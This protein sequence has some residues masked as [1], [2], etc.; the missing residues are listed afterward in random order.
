MLLYDLAGQCIIV[1]HGSKGVV[2]NSSQW[3]PEESV[4]EGGLKSWTK[5]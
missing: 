2:A 4:N 5:G 3:F 1:F